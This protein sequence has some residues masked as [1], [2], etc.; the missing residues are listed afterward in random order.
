MPGLVCWATVP[1]S[2]QAFWALSLIHPMCPDLRSFCIDVALLWQTA[3]VYSNTHTH[4]H[5]H[6][7]VR[8]LF[9]PPSLSLP[10]FF[11]LQFL[12][13]I[14]SL[15]SFLS[16]SSEVAGKSSLSAQKPWSLIRPSPGRR[17]HGV[18]MTTSIPG[19]PS[20][21]KDQLKG[22]VISLGHTVFILSSGPCTS[23]VLWEE[24]GRE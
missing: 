7:H 21:G 13:P 9:L 1:V 3:S 23:T 15:S 14:P 8:F 5:T 10:S 16:S 6:T 17:V 24:G 19:Y 20:G 18:T 12:S 4:T 2:W 22:T 11:L